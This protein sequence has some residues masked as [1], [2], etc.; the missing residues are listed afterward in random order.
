MNTALSILLA[1]ALIPAAEPT[2]ELTWDPVTT[3]VSGALTVIQK[4]L[5][6]AQ[7]ADAAPTN[8]GAPIKAVSVPSASV[9]ITHGVRWWFSV[10][11]VNVAGEGDR[12]ATLSIEPVAGSKPV[13]PV[14]LTAT[15]GDPQP[16]PPP[17]PAIK[18]I[19]YTVVG[20]SLTL[21]PTTRHATV[22]PEMT[23]AGTLKA[24]S[25]FHRAIG[26]ANTIQVGVYRGTDTAPAQLLAKTTQ[27]AV[28]AAEGWQDIPLTAPAV[29]ATGDFLWVVI[30]TQ[31][32]IVLTASTNIVATSLVVKGWSDGIPDTWDSTTVMTK[33]SFAE[34]V[35]V[36]YETQ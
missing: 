33:L 31:R 23:E 5:I 29:V 6:Y 19:G 1:M 34:N 11:A 3:D 2:V 26:S 21:S 20:S 27:T 8:W 28:V 7:A 35:V 15:V 24:V 14:G 10:S 36:V 4:Y 25:V 22:L 13:V 12:S 18:Q 17:V 32:S 9:I 30:I 16:L